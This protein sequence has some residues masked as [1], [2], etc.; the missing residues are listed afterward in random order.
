MFIIDLYLRYENQINL[1]KDLIFFAGAYK[2][3][4]YLKNKKFQDSCR[5]IN[6]NLKF[7]EK[8]EP[9]L[10]EFI[11]DSEIKDISIRFVHWQNYPRKLSD[12]GYKLLLRINYD[13]D[14]PWYGW[15][16]NTGINF[17]QPLKFFSKSVYLDKND[18]FFIADKD[19]KFKNF[20]EIRCTFIL[21]LPFKNI[22]NFDFKERIE[23]EPVFYTRY[24]YTNWK[25]NYDDLVILRELKGSEYFHYELSQKRVLKK[26]SLA[27]YIFLKIK[28]FFSYK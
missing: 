25:K 5:E 17:E 9:Q 18:I 13:N 7:R 28:L 20:K 4:A 8:I 11:R 3:F 2:I 10:E 15:I 1:V 27:R 16:S 19:Q 6:E 24:F 23:Y 12:D 22:I 26:Y 21:H 14:K